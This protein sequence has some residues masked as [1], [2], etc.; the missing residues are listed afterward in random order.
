MKKGVCVCVV[1]LINC[2]EIIARLGI[3]SLL[4][5][6]TSFNYSSMHSIFQAKSPE[7]KQYQ[8][9]VVKNA[10]VMAKEL[11]KRGYDVVSGNVK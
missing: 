2:V 10:Q 7:F 6:S 1:K 4:I 9:Q 3:N 11:L 8:I 5:K